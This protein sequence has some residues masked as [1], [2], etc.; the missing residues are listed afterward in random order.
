[1]LH[2]GA[3]ASAGAP[4]EVITTDAL[5]AVFGVETNVRPVIEYGN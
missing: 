2:R 5:R 4:R 3:L 1:M